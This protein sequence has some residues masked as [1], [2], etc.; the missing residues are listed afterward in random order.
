M[1]RAPLNPTVPWRITDDE[2]RVVRDLVEKS[3]TCDVLNGLLKRP[4]GRPRR[5]TVQALFV[6]LQ[7]VATRKKHS[8]LLIEAARFLNSL[9]PVQRRSLGLQD[10]HWDE[11][12]TYDRLD[13]LFNAVARTLD[14]AHV[15]EVNGEAATIDASWVANR[16]IRASLPSDLPSSRAVAVDG[17]DLETWAALHADVETLELDGE[18]TATLAEESEGTVEPMPAKRS[19]R[20]IRRAKVRDVGPDGRKVYT[21]DPDARAGHR[22]ATNSRPAGKYIGYEVHVV[23]QTRD[24]T[25]RNLVDDAQLGPEVPNLIMAIAVSPA[26]SHRTKAVL[27]EL[28]RLKKERQELRE[29]VWDRGYSMLKPEHGQTQ[30][31]RAGFE[32]VFDLAAVQRGRRPFNTDDVLVD[33]QLYSRHLPKNLIGEFGYERGLTIPNA[34]QG[35]CEL[36][37]V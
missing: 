34:K 22:S 26:G 27:P 11:D 6:A 16:L 28:M 23:A 7:A 15:V 21:A 10:R 20:P 5:M 4:G 17:T 36:D 31:A 25:S 1:K 37:G 24:I 13:R 8:M 35:L 3:G 2:F 33:G 32:F 14:Q 30:L 29:I 19:F 9:S 18:A 12:Q